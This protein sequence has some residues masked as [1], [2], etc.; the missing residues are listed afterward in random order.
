M[1]VDRYCNECLGYYSYDVDEVDNFKKCRWCG[2]EDT[3]EAQKLSILLFELKMYLEFINNNFQTNLK[4][5]IVIFNVFFE[6][7]YLNQ[8]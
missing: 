4:R 8:R 5:N 1:E 3:E 2:S 7:K 6:F